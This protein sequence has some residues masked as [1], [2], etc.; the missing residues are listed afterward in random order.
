MRA[1][2][3]LVLLVACGGSSRGPAWPKERLPETDGGESIAPRPS[4][5]ALNEDDGEDLEVTL[6]ETKPEVAATK[7]DPKPDPGVGVT[8]PGTTTPDEINITTEDI[9]VNIEDPQAP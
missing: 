2:L 4:T 1:A 3:V 8:P 6:D 9:I 5:A 7:D